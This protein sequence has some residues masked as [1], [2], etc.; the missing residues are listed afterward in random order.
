M[1]RRSGEARLR[2]SVGHLADLDGVPVR[3]LNQA[4]TRNLDR[5]PEDFMIQLG[6]EEMESLRSQIVILDGGP[7]RGDRRGMHLKYP[8]QPEG[9]R[10]LPDHATDTTR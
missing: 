5:F 4:A 8:P 7:E 3:S 10:G 6:W 1:S 9:C 2:S